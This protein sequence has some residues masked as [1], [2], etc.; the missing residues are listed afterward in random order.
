MAFALAGAMAPPPDS[1]A[2]AGE[3]SVTLGSGDTATVQAGGTKIET[4]ASG[5]LKVFV[6]GH[7]SVTV[8]TDDGVT[9]RPADNSNGAA[10]TPK[11]GERLADGTI[12][13]GNYFAATPADAPSLYTW[14]DGNRYCQGLEAFGHD[15]WF[16][17]TLDQLK[18]LYEN[19]DAGAFSGTFSSTRSKQFAT[20][21]WSSEERIGYVL[22]AWFQSFADGEL[23]GAPKNKDDYELSVRCVRAEF[24]P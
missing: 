14:N 3:I 16:L 21:Y 23:G 18:H 24:Y 13:G 20:W 8:F 15:D 9:L 12:Y 11:G 10:G 17:P 4:D 6:N 19:K 2:L 22:D 5:N 1:Q 7:G